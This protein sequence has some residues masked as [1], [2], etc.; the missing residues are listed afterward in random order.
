MGAA[1]RRILIIFRGG[2][3][4]DLWAGVYRATAKV[5]LPGS[6]TNREETANGFV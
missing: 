5:K 2:R 4:I 1:A 6:V 3:D